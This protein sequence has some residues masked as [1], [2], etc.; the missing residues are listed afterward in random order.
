MDFDEVILFRTEC[1]Y[2]SNLLH[3]IQLW[4]FVLAT[5]HWKKNLL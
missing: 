3:I 4:V 2:I 1:A 5:I